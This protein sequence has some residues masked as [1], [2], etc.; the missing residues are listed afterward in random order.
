MLIEVLISYPDP[1]DNCLPP[2][3]YIREWKTM[4]VSPFEWYKILSRPYGYN[5]YRLGK[6][7]NKSVN[8][9]LR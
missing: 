6:Y 4:E 3:I 9:E 8:N 7:I 5:Y 1:M 2:Q